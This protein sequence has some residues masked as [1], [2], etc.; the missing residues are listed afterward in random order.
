MIVEMGFEAGDGVVFGEFDDGVVH[1]EWGG[2]Y[3]SEGG[4]CF[5]KLSWLELGASS[6][7]YISIISQT[8]SSIIFAY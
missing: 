1:A 6:D 4:T 2:G 5:L 8:R 7:G 3:T